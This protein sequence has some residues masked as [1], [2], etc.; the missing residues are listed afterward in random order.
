MENMC[1]TCHSCAIEG[2]VRSKILSGEV[3]PELTRSDLS[4]PP[5]SIEEYNNAQNII[6]FAGN[7]GVGTAYI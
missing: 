3:L 5:F 2:F 1:H 6:A 7:E 4:S